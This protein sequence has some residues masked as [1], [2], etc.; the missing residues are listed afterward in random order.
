[1]ADGH[2]LKIK[3]RNLNKYRHFSAMVQAK[4]TTFHS[5]SLRSTQKTILALENLNS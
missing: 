2:I 1:M 5:M 4:A 3:N